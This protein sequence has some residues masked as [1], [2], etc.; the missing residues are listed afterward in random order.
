MIR[1]FLPPSRSCDLPS[2]RD[3]YYKTFFDET[4]GAIIRHYCCEDGSSGE[5]DDADYDDY[6][7]TPK[8]E[9]SVGG[10][11]AKEKPVSSSSLFQVI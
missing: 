10:I 3:Q 7:N 8:S 2:S 9:D 6:E 4:D 5:N 11:Y 1:Q